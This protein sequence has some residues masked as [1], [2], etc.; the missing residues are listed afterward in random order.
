[1]LRLRKSVEEIDL[2]KEAGRVIDAAMMKAFGEARVGISEVEVKQIVQNEIVRLGA[3]P[4]FA[5]VQFGENSAMPH[6]DSGNRLL[7][8]NDLVLMDCGCS[9]EGYNTDQTRVGVV[10]DPSEEMERVYATVLKAEEAALEKIRSGMSCGT[11]DGIARRIIEDA[12]YGEQFTHRLG[13]GIGLEVHEPPYIVRGNPQ[14]LL[15]GM[16]HSVEPGVYLEGNFG[17]RIEDLVCITEGG[18]DILTFSPKDLFQ[19]SV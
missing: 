1:M 5:A 10:G 16:C 13:H 9:V 19:I 18:V 8:K 7:K 2:M 17:I 15:P 3:Q 6:H 14:E 4:T 11:A 12:G